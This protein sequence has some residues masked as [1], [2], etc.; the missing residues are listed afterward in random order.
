MNCPTA[1]SSIVA[2][3]IDACIDL[4][5]TYDTLSLEVNACKD[6]IK[7]ISFLSCHESA[8]VSSILIDQKLMPDVLLSILV[9]SN[10]KLAI[11][12][13]LNDILQH[14]HEKNSSGN[15]P[16]TVI[17][18]DRFCS[19][20]I[21]K[22]P[23]S[24]NPLEVN[25]MV[26]KHCNPWVCREFL[27]D[28]LFAVRTL[29][30]FMKPFSH[31]EVFLPITDFYDFL[32]ITHMTL[33]HHEN[34]KIAPSSTWSM[35]ADK[36]VQCV[37]AQSAADNEKKPIFGLIISIS[38]IL[39]CLSET[40]IEEIIVDFIMKIFDLNLPL[41]STKKDLCQIVGSI[42]NDDVEMFQEILQH[43]ALTSNTSLDKHCQSYFKQFCSI[44][45]NK[46]GREKLIKLV[47]RNMVVDF[48]VCDPKSFLC[49]AASVEMAEPS[50]RDI[51]QTSFSDSHICMQL[52]KA[53][54]LT[55]ALDAAV[56]LTLKSH[57]PVIYP[58]EIIRLDQ[59]IW[60]VANSDS[61]WTVS[62]ASFLVHLYYWISIFEAD[63]NF[64]FLP[65]LLNLS[66][67]NAVLCCDE[68]IKDTNLVEII[69]FSNLKDKI[70][71]VFPETA[72]AICSMQIAPSLLKATHMNVIMISK[73]IKTALDN[74]E[75]PTFS[76]KAAILYFA[77]KH[78][79]RISN[80]LLDLK[81]AQS[82]LSSGKSLPEYFT[83]SS[84]CRDP[85]VLMKCDLAIWKSEMRL[86]LLSILEKVL[87]INEQLLKSFDS[88]GILGSICCNQLLVA[89]D[90]VIVRCLLTLLS[91]AIIT[92]TVK[93]S[94]SVSPIFC[95]STLNTI[96]SIVKNRRGIVA[97][98]VR[99]RLNDDCSTFLIEFV[100]EAMFDADILTA[101]LV[102]K[103]T[104]A[105][106]R[107]CTA[108]VS[109][110]MVIRNDYLFDDEKYQKLAFTS[111]TVMINSFYLVQ[112][113][114]GMAANVW[115]EEES[116]ADVCQICRRAML[117]MINAIETMRSD[118]DSLK[119]ECA[120]ALG[121]LASLC[122]VEISEGNRKTSILQSIWEAT[123]RAS[124]ALGN[125]Y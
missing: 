35:F 88:R 14:I 113:P 26:K 45:V 5:G 11:K 84:L 59:S 114:A 124:I 104:S 2:G 72:H 51:F 46:V 21:G 22:R 50:L 80:R 97:S 119:N 93:H 57:Y 24:A 75:D 55:Y 41:I 44:I 99:E 7:E 66:L 49:G 31:I 86:I 90:I 15:P 60:S 3:C 52:T 16:S 29:V 56:I 95:V 17:T 34:L 102:D 109:L 32:L 71:T 40:T 121:K 87:L 8:K 27:S 64:P 30:D 96:R 73:F 67:E 76:H 94:E 85:L 6:A 91:N 42:I 122:K 92:R 63:K 20:R 65:D 48:F 43:Y 47:E 82:L 53:S 78:D 112:G 107:L 39:I 89:R 105:V 38:F 125:R 81:S 4:R 33:V 101:V 123:N 18:V 28:Y 61:I 36:F 74:I 111:L 68:R 19:N 58:D 62:H 100:H 117:R 103:G 69:F 79:K 25:D 116:G 83:Y 98:L 9:R 115:I 106:S 37:A 70:R 23:Y 77:G 13:L 110:R 12:L 10:I 118:K 120:M 1:I 54:T 108:D